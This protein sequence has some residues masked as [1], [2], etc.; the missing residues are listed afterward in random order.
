MKAGTTSLYRDL[1]ANPAVFFSDDKEPGNLNHD[2]VLEPEGL[3]DYARHFEK[4]KPGQI[5]GEASTTYSQRPQYS[6]IPQRALKILGG[7]TRII[8]VVREPVARIISQ[9]MHAWT[10]G[11]RR[12]QIDEAVRRR[13]RFIDF[14]RYAWQITPWIETFGREQVMIVRFETYVEN[15]RETVTEI[16]RFLGIEPRADLVN[17][18]VAYN[19]SADKPVPRGPFAPLRHSFL[20]RRMLRPVL[21]PAAREKLRNALLPRAKDQPDPPSPEIVRFILDELR[22]DAEALRVI[23]G[24]D[25]PVWD[26]DEIL[27]RHGCRKAP[28][29]RE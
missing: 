12:E 27:E 4:A 11:L 19:R 13:P 21:G 28:A 18:D 6:S 17:V 14:S 9:H 3:A 15:R 7:D 10:I 29:T 23:M 20:Y 16:S 2:D 24:C 22:E 8:Y 25:E 26:F 1:I 5:C